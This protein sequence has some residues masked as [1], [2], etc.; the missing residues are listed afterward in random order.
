M[1][2]CVFNLFYKPHSVLKYYSIVRGCWML[3]ALSITFHLSNLFADI[4]I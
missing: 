4:K 1:Q 3:I 2:C